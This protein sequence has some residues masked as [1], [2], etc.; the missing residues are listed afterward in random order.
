MLSWREYYEEDG[1]GARVEI[2]GDAE[3]VG[4][5][6]AELLRDADGRY[7]QH[8]DGVITLRDDNGRVVR[9]RI[10]GHERDGEIIVGELIS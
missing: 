9:H 4:R 6:T 2:V 3:P 7:V 5:F 8:A 1:V 10:T